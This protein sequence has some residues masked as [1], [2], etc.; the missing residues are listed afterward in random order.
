MDSGALRRVLH[1]V[2]V[3]VSANR[4]HV[5]CAVRTYLERTPPRANLIANLRR[6]GLLSPDDPDLPA[7]V[8]PMIDNRVSG[9]FRFQAHNQSE[10]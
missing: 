7:Y 3:G 9:P 8:L 5:P 6:V 10:A 2:K 1:G 4:D